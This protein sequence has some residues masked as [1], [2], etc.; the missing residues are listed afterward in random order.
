MDILF[1]LKKEIFPNNV[2]FKLQMSEEANVVPFDKSTLSFS[3]A[4][5]V[6]E[7]WLQKLEVAKN[8]GAHVEPQKMLGI[9]QRIVEC[10]CGPDGK[11]DQL[12]SIDYHSPVSTFGVRNEATY[13]KVE[14][15]SKQILVTLRSRSRDMA[16]SKV[17]LKSSTTKEK[18]AALAA[19]TE[20]D[21]DRRERFANMICKFFASDDGCKKGKMC[22]AKHVPK[23]K[24]CT[25][26][27]TRDQEV[28]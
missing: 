17:T 16:T 20:R 11:H 23:D 28:R 3:S 1:R 21:Q 7:T 26:P 6:L 27:E 24:G 5:N 2:N 25:I 9:V 8:F 14:L 10:V 13:A 12:F 15:L 22:E 19:G 18:T 4:S